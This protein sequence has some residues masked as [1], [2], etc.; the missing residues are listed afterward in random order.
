MF[1]IICLFVV[2]AV[3]SISA[4]PKPGVLAYSAP[5]IAAAPASA[6]YE[7]TYHGNI[8]PLAAYAAAPYFAAPLAYSA[9]YVAA[10]AAPV[11]LK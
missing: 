5:L 6:V 3:A 7:R 8:A 10:A 2:I 11:L 9:P 1:K 4:D